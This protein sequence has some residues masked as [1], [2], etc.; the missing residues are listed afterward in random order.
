MDDSKHILIPA[1]FISIMLHLIATTMLFFSYQDNIKAAYPNL[2]SMSETDYIG[3]TTSFLAANSLTVIG[4]FTELVML[5]VGENLFKEKHSLLVSTIH[6]VGAILYISYGFQMWQFSSL[7]AL[8]AIFSLLPLG[9]E[10]LQI[11]MKAR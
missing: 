4:L 6:Y 1:K 2:T 5:F 9:L 11:V 7:W 3:G 8:W 10:I